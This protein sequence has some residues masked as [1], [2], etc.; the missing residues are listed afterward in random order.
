[1]DWPVL[2]EYSR[3]SI[4][5]TQRLRT[6]GS[7]LHS[8]AREVALER[9]RAVMRLSAAVSGERRDRPALV[10]LKVSFVEQ[11]S[12]SFRIHL[13]YRVYTFGMGANFD[14]MLPR[15][16]S[17]PRQRTDCITGTPT[18]EHALANVP[19]YYRSLPFVLPLWPGNAQRTAL[20]CAGSFTVR[21][22]R[23]AGEST[24]RDWLNDA[25][26]ALT[27]PWTNH[28]RARD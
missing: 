7:A 28:H 12:L 17:A 10:R 26:G 22:Y 2:P 16:F 18:H 5:I 13:D 14:P 3:C 20:S 8:G 27:V 11:K 4:A 19:I 1:M 9:R 6:T 15:G 24:Y 23:D 21:G 25:G